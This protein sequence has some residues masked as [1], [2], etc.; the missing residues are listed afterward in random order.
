MLCNQQYFPYF[1]APLEFALIR[2]TQ[3]W[4]LEFETLILE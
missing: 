3:D 1:S 4:Q 2:D